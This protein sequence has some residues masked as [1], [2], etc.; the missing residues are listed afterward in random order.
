M[1]DRAISANFCLLGYP[2]SQKIL[3]RQKWRPFWIFKFFAKHKNTCIS[4]TVWDRAMSTKLLPHRVSVKTIL[5]KVQWIFHLP[6]MSAILSFQ[7]FFKNAKHK[8]ACILKTV[9]DR[10]I[11]MKFLTHRVTL[12]SSWPN[13]QKKIC[14]IKNWRPIWIFKFFTKIAKHKNACISK[15]LPDRANLAKFLTHRVSVKTSLSKTSPY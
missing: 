11:S 13:F 15:T 12:L 5:S 10:A 7:S 4:K 6:K 14:L 1:R 3:S 9:L 8:N 2:V